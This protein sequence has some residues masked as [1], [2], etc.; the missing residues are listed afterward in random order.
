MNGAIADD[1]EA[2]IRRPSR[3]CQVKLTVGT[4]GTEHQPAIDGQ[5]RASS[6]VSKQIFG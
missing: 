5:S 1:Y 4:F 3:G 6:R 2:A